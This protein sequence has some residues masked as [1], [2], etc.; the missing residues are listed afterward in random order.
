MDSESKRYTIA[1]FTI[2]ITRVTTPRK[3]Q[4]ANL[5]ILLEFGNARNKNSGT[6]HTHICQVSFTIAYSYV[7]SR[8]K[9]KVIERIVFDLRG[10]DVGALLRYQPGPIFQLQHD[11]TSIKPRKIYDFRTDVT[12]LWNP[13]SFTIGTTTLKQRDPKQSSYNDHFHNTLIFLFRPSQ[14]GFGWKCIS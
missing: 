6:N 10:L 1:T 9:I 11:P 8:Y 12:T 13:T 5:F 4:N 14:P 7:L 3:I 2:I